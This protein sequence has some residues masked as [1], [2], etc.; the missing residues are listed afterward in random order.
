MLEENLSIFPSVGLFAWLHKHVLTPLS[1][2]SIPSSPVLA[3]VSESVDGSNVIRAFG[4]NQIE[5]FIRQSEKRIDANNTNQFA[6][7]VV[8]EWF[9]M[10]MQL[11][12]GAILFLVTAS[13]TL[14]RDYLSPGIIG[15]AFNY[16]LAVD[17][18]L[19]SIIQ[20]WSHLEMSMVSPERI[21]E[22]IGLPSEAPH[23]IPSTEPKASWPDQGQVS[24]EHVS[25]RYKEGGDLVLKDLS[26]D[27]QPAEKI[28]IVGRTG[29]GK[30]SLTM[31]L[32][33]I[34]EICGGRILIDGIDTT[35]LGLQTLRSR[36]SI[37][38]QAPVLF[39]GTIR[40]YLD[41]FDEF[42]DSMLWDCLRKVQMA[43]A[44][45]SM[46]GKL[47]AVMEENG[48]NFSVGERQM[49]CMAR[50]LLSESRVV[51]MDEA[52]AAID[53]KTDAILQKVIR[54]EFTKSTVITI[55]HRLDTVLDADRIMVLDAGQI[56]EFDSP[57]ALIQRGNGHFF[58]LAK[59][60]G[61]LERMN[62]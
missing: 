37:I 59:E 2:K 58:D 19:E 3:H 32:F 4:S 39:K 25:F 8:A 62:I 56:V 14:M 43:E 52:T 34:N 44:I 16:G 46:E 61:Y 48:D 27:L 60:G 6:G 49:L 9:A 29:A 38:T 31:A 7:F 30:S 18:G 23:V 47:Q 1:C 13:L 36:L 28:G 35:K 10:R 20:T 33:R 50:A 5:R 45:A 55:A 41:P 15:L 24:F 22:Y 40:T 26:F 57:T 17:E 21:S 54:Q 51:I 12:G 53:Q 42:Q 11:M